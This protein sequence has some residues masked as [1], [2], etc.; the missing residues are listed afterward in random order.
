MANSSI[1][2]PA[3][4]TDPGNAAA[5]VA[6]V[7]PCFNDGK[8]VGEALASVRDQ[9]VAEVIVVNDGSS[10]PDTLRVLGELEQEGIRVIHQEN[11]GLAAARMAGVRATD[12]PYVQPLDSDDILA[13][14]VLGRLAAMLDADPGLDAVWGN[15]EIF[16]DRNFVEKTWDGFDPWRITYLN[17]IPATV[18]HRRSSLLESGGWKG[19]GY[20]DWNLWMTA[21]E[22]GW[23]GARI[24]DV[25]IYYRVQA[26]SRLLDQAYESD[27]RHRADMRRDHKALYRE[28]FA[29]WRRSESRWAL[30]IVWPLIEMLP[31]VNGVQKNQMI[32]FSRDL[33]EPKQRN[34]QRSL[35]S[36]AA[37][38]VR[39]SAG[40][41]S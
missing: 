37:A 10:D 35:K 14:G 41:P 21:G 9:G 12:A 23:R 38:K 13:P 39:G 24:D 5:R 27:H 17:E 16:G 15:I 20:E 36:R 33:I 3:A 31:F 32:R 22:V 26:T 25:S 6:V 4:P 18:M 8:L 40:R 19:R 34:T 7:I 1:K 2:A 11:A 28:R 29:N 30:K